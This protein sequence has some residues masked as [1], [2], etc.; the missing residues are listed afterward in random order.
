VK[1]TYAMEATMSVKNTHGLAFEPLPIWLSA[2]RRR[3]IEQVPGGR[4]PVVAILDTGVADHDWFRGPDADPILTHLGTT[5]WTSG[6]G[7]FVAGLIRQHAPDARVLSLSLDRTGDGHIASGQLSEGL[8]TLQT[9]DFVDV[10]CM[11][12]GFRDLDDDD[13]ERVDRLEHLI[14]EIG[15]RGTLVVAAAGNKKDG[16]TR[17]VYP[18]KL[19][20]RLGG[21][22]L[23]AV[24]AV[25]AA[26]EVADFSITGD[27]V[28]RTYVGVDV[29][30][31]TPT[32]GAEGWVD[33]EKVDALDTVETFEVDPCEDGHGFGR[34]SGTSFAA[35]GFAGLVAQAMLDTPDGVADVS[36]DGANGRLRRALDRPVHDRALDRPVHDRALDRPVHD[37][38]LDRPVHDRAPARGPE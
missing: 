30:S 6:H 32:P 37:R 20:E 24:G 10:I 36:P 3:P 12:V 11:A 1:N 9:H 28:T 31:T 25:D 27:W 26:G 7:T 23:I 34:G 5:T 38:A 18:A 16:E 17:P 2:P 15:H 13:R 14:Q 35:A 8:T 29:V 4:R 19:A 22:P 33:D 21:P